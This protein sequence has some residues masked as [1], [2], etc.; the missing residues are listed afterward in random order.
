MVKKATATVRAGMLLIFAVSQTGK[1]N[2]KN[3]G[4][5]MKLLKYKRAKYNIRL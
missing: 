2:E 4:I 5:D 1:M 3:L